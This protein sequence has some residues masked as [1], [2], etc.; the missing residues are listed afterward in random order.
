HPVQEPA[1]MDRRNGVRNTVARPEGFGRIDRI[2]LS[3]I[4]MNPGKRLAE[5]APLYRIGLRGSVNCLW[6]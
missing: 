2:T 5:E 4:D 6:T 3:T 1:E